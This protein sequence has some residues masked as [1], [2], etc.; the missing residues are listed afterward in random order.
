[1]LL[2]G[3]TLEEVKELKKYFSLTLGQKYENILKKV[4]FLK[5]NEKKVVLIIKELRGTLT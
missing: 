5:K 1:M 4:E 3:V 2:L